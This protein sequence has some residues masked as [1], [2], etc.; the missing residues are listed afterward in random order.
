MDTNM[1]DTEGRE[2]GGVN[3]SSLWSIFKRCWYAVLLIGIAVGL[4]AG[5]IASY[6]YVPRYAA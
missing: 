6:L 2:S 4:V 5:S 1:N 3:L